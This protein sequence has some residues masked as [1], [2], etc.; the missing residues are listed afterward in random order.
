MFNIEISGG[1]SIKIKFFFQLEIIKS[2]FLPFLGHVYEKPI[3][4]S[5]FQMILNDE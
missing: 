3:L 2:R 1:E 4:K 5:N